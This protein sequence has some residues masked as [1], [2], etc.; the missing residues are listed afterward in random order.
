MWVSVVYLFALVINLMSFNA[1]LFFPLIC[2]RCGQTA[3]TLFYK[4]NT[5][6]DGFFSPIWSC[7]HCIHTQPLQEH[8]QEKKLTTLKCPHFKLTL[9]MFVVCPFLKRTFIIFFFIIVIC[10]IPAWSVVVIRFG[11]FFLRWIFFNM[12]VRF[13]FY[14][15]INV[16][17]WIMNILLWHFLTLTRELLTK[18]K[19]IPFEFCVA[20]CLYFCLFAFVFV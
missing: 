2:L 11:Y 4:R 20:G 5:F 6:F 15:H 18:A 13:D 14:R 7:V 9:D 17:H 3:A 16:H 8:V 19:N 12:S 10:L 1:T